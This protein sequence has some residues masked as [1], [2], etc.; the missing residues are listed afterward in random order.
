[1]K[2]RVTVWLGVAAACA[3]LSG[4]SNSHI[5]KVKSMPFDADPSLTIEQAFDHRKVCDSVK[6]DTIK[7]DRGRTLVEYR[8]YFKDVDAVVGKMSTPSNPLKSIDEVFQWSVNKGAAPV[9]A[10]AGSEV[11]FTD[12]TLKDRAYG[13]AGIA[14]KL[15]DENTATTFQEYN[16]QFSAQGWMNFLHS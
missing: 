5:A 1:M 15:I 3:A 8:C 16:T 12:G 10:Y 6:W 11:N 9:L 7:D 4:C 13:D 14:E 2:I